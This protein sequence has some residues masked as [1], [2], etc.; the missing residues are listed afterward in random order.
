MAYRWQAVGSEEERRWDIGGRWMG[1][2]GRENEIVIAVM[3]EM[4]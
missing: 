3:G 4:Y 1:G 2:G